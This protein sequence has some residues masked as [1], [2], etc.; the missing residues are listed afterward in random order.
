[1]QRHNLF[2]PDELIAEFKKMSEETGAP[3]A[4]LI[5]RAM[6]EYVEKRK[7]EIRDKK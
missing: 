3:M 4:E 5:R 1:M 6:K 7:H 2:F